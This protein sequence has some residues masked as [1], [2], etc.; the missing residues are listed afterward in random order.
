MRWLSRGVTILVTLAALAGIGFLIW[1]KLPKTIVDG[2]FMTYTKFRDGSRLTHGSPVLIAGVA[3]G[4]VDHI[5]IEGRFARM[6]LRLQAGLQ[7][8][9]DSFIT[10]RA[11]SLFGDSYLEIIPPI[12]EPGTSPE[13]MLQAN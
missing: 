4:K 5:S 9:A 12:A 2:P 7:I 6:D 11:D 3:V 13:R 8:P 10:R 1:H